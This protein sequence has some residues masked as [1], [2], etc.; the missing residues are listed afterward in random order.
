MLPAGSISGAPKPATVRIIR[1]AEKEDRGFYT[2][3]FGYFDGKSFRQG[4]RLRFRSGG[5]ITVNSDCSAE[6]QEVL[7]KVYLPC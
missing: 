2:G 4:N 7:Q 1:E 3:I 5:G 6:Y